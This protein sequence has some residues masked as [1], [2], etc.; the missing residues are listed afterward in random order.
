MFENLVHLED[1]RFTVYIKLERDD[2][3][4]V[5]TCELQRQSNKVKVMSNEVVNL[6]ML[7]TEHTNSYDK[8]ILTRTFLYLDTLDPMIYV[9][10]VW[11]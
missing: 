11:L 3:T 10:P 4:S 7:Y 1:A 9:L 8:T 6:S 2:V 5:S